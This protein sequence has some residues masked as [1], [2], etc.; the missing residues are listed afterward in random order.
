MITPELVKV[1]VETYSNFND[2]GIKSRKREISD[3]RFVYF[4]LCKQYCIPKVTLSY[5]GSLVN[6]DHASAINGITKC[7][8]LLGTPDFFGNKVY[9]EV[10]KRIIELISTDDENKILLTDDINLVNQYWRLKH[11]KL[12]DKTHILLSKY[13][14][15]INALEERFSFLDD[16]TVNAVKLLN[17]KDY[18]DFID[19]NKLFIKVRSKLNKQ[20]V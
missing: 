12:I 14:H 17:D 10:E 8:I 16:E 3:L 2:I 18:K 20:K 5:I 6:R 13:I 15:K 9:Y 11:I 4:S 7:S 1:L 19:R